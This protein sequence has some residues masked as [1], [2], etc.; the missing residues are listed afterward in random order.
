M[1]ASAKAKVSNEVR[2]RWQEGGTRQKRLEMPLP[3]N[4]RQGARKC[5]PDLT[6]P[7]EYLPDPNLPWQSLSVFVAGRVR[8]LHYKKLPV[9]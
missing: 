3:P 8:S 5:G 4:Q 1:S 9:L 2:L 7:L 6:T